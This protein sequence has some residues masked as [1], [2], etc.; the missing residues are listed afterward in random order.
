MRGLTPEEEEALSDNLGP[1]DQKTA[2]YVGKYTPRRMTIERLIKRK[3][4]IELETDWMADPQNP[5][6]GQEYIFVHWEM[7]P[8]GRIA[9]ACHR[10][11]SANPC[12]NLSK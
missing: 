6:D 3:L 5:N 1:F 2:I 7:T 9:L 10:A 11:A 8:L 12:G 4:L